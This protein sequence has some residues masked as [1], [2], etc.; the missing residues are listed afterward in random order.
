MS[1]EDPLKDACPA[2]YEPDPL[3]GDC[4]PSVTVAKPA[5]PKKKASKPKKKASKPKKKASKPKKK[6]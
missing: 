2:G 4:M 5:K 6:K 1:E 3:T